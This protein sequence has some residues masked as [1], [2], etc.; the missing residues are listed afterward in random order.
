[1]AEGWC[2][3]PW[4]LVSQ[5]VG[6]LQGQGQ[7]AGHR[8]ETQGPGEGP[9]APGAGGGRR[10][11]QGLGAPEIGSCW[12]GSSRSQEREAEQ[13]GVRGGRRLA[14]GSVSPACLPN[15]Y[16]PAGLDRTKQ[17]DGKGRMALHPKAS[18]GVLFYRSEL[19]LPLP[20]TASLHHHPSP[21]KPWAPATAS[22][23]THRP[24]P[25]LAAVVVGLSSG[26]RRGVDRGTGQGPG[27]R[28]SP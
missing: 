14:H 26:R 2:S 16:Q 7:C 18:S 28:S 5:R 8:K 22:P 13:G 19:S 11:K 17:R 4:T 15:W 23:P 1:M 12:A 20:T 27:R 6:E 10:L 9:R 24:S 25:T 21:Q 3:R